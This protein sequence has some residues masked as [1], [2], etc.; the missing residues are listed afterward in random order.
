MKKFYTIAFFFPFIVNPLWG[1]LPNN[2]NN[3]I[4]DTATKPLI[5]ENEEKV[6]EDC[7]EDDQELKLE[8]KINDFDALVK[9]AGG[10]AIWI[11]QKTRK[12]YCLLDLL[13]MVQVQPS[14]T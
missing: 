10:G 13:V 11:Q 9:E 12:S 8:F 1:A 3:S 2:A 6:S 14:T 7:F 5:S 4:K